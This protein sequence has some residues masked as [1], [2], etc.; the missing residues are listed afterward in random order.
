[1]KEKLNSYI[2]DVESLFGCQHPWRW[3]ASFR[4]ILGCIGNNNVSLPTAYYYYRM[5]N[6]WSHVE[7]IFSWSHSVLHLHYWIPAFFLIRIRNGVLSGSQLLFLPIQYAT[8]LN[9]NLAQSEFYFCLCRIKY[10]IW[11]CANAPRWYWRTSNAPSPAAAL[12]SGSLRG[13][14]LLG[15]MRVYQIMV[16]TTTA[17][18]ARTLMDHRGEFFI[19]CC[20]RV[21]V[22]GLWTTKNA[23]I[24]KRNVELSGLLR[25]ELEPAALRLSERC[26]HM[27]FN[28]L[29]KVVLLF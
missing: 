25:L 22:Q 15:L 8:S 13:T 20:V 1:M 5:K 6:L 7:I 26:F 14:A 12:M 27:V 17:E 23:C 29:T 18:F 24:F 9:P 10:K 16:P 11:H 4:I 3:S 19:V 2:Y 28:S 21:Y